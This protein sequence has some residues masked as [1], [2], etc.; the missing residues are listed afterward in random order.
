MNAIR[1]SLG[2]TGRGTPRFAFGFSGSFVELENLELS[3]VNHGLIDHSML[4]LGNPEGFRYIIA[5]ESAL[6]RFFLVR[7]RAKNLTGQWFGQIWAGKPAE[8]GDFLRQSAQTRMEQ[9]TEE[10][11]LHYGQEAVIEEVSN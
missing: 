6:A 2:Q 4:N 1:Q 3:M 8:F 10:T 9:I 11:F 5:T 7:E